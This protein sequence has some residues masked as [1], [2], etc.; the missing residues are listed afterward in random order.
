LSPGESYKYV[1]RAEWME[2]GKRIESLREVKV[3]AG[4]VIN[5]DFNRQPA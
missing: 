2:D 3:E 5:V 1:L 4:D